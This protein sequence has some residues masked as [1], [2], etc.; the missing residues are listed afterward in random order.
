M[1]TMNIAEGDFKAL[2]LDEDSRFL[3][4]DAYQAVTKANRWG[5][6]RRPD[7]PGTRPCEHCN[8]QNCK[9]RTVNAS[10]D[11][12]WC[13]DQC[14]ICRGK[15]FSEQGFMFSSASE[16][17]EIDLYMEYG[18]HSGASYGWTL[19][20]MEVIAKKGWP[21]FVAMVG[22]KPDSPDSTGPVAVL[23]N[24]V[25]TAKVMDS[26]INE[27]MAKKTMDP[28]AFAKSLQANPEVRKEIPDIDAQ[29][30]AIQQFSEGKMSYAEMRSLCG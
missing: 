8:G 2:D 28:L 14:R 21:A 1:N 13:V 7:V 12:C 10:G 5:Y 26:A 6:L 27:A 20:N 16:L 30:S 25:S 4:E 17:R 9:G 24:L 11:R 22:V 3:L 19:R 15:G 29:V 23:T 18:G